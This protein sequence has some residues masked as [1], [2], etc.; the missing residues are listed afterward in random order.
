MSHSTAR[1]C[2]DEHLSSTVTSRGLAALRG[3]VR[4][5]DGR[6]GKTDEKDVDFLVGVSTLSSLRYI[7]IIF[8][9]VVCQGQKMVR[10]F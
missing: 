2:G 3:G 5:M 8:Q 4:Q 6:N 9:Q 1:Q 10:E 7:D